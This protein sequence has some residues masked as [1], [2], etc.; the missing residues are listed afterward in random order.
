[1]TDQDQA[2]SDIGANDNPPRH[3]RYQRLVRLD[4]L[5]RHLLTNDWEQENASQI[6]RGFWQRIK[7]NA[8]LKVVREDLAAIRAPLL[9]I[10]AYCL[11][12]LIPDQTADSL[13]T[14][15]EES[16]VWLS[17][18]LLAWFM[19]FLLLGLALVAGA[20]IGFD[21]LDQRRTSYGR[22]AALYGYDDSTQFSRRFILT[23][24][25][26]VAIPLVTVYAVLA[27]H[28]PTLHSLLHVRLSVYVFCG[29][30]ILSVALSYLSLTT[31]GRP[32]NSMILVGSAFACASVLIL[33]HAFAIRDLPPVILVTV[34]IMVVLAGLELLELFSAYSRLPL[35]SIAIG[36]FV[37]FSFMDWNDNHELRRLPVNG[38][39]AGYWDVESAF[40]SWI[41][42]R[43]DES[44]KYIGARQ[45]YPVFIIAA[46]GG[47][48]R[49]AAMTAIVMETLRTVCP[50]A[51]KHTFLT[52]GVSGGSVGATLAHATMAREGLGS[53][54]GRFP[55]DSLGPTTPT[56]QAASDDLL[57]PLLFGTLF[58][59]LPSQVSPFGRLP[60]FPQL[61]DRAQYL[62]RGLS[63]TYQ[64]YT[65]GLSWWGL[66]LARFNPNGSELDQLPF[67]AL[68]QGPEG[69][70]PALMLLAT[71]VDSGRRV[72]ASHLRMPY[73]PDVNGVRGC[74]Q[75]ATD[76]GNLTVQERSRVISLS[77]LLPNWD[78]SASTAAILSARFPGITPAASVTCGERKYRLVDG[79]YFEN[80]GLTTAGEVARA[81]M[82]TAL[83][84]HASVHI[85]SIENSNASSD[86]RFARGL[87]PSGPPSYFS[88]LLSPFRAI[89]GSRE[90]HANIARTSIDDL[91]RSID[92]ARCANFVCIQQI[93]F[94][95]RR[96]PTP[97]PLGWSLSEAAVGEIR[98]QL[99]DS[100][101]GL[102]KDCVELGFRQRSASEAFLQVAANMKARLD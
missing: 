92:T 102:L 90:A 23:I 24:G 20:K 82:R 84:N 101:D 81:I 94:H 88:E 39:S 98:R 10:G 30:C 96:C 74:Q 28:A 46:E 86:W 100:S 53:G 31:R 55:Q 56:I 8:W 49:A 13:R 26:I 69:N 63:A 68:W 34:W 29:L 41:G 19:V 50:D 42:A 33:T 12:V 37:L 89:D 40:A 51:L 59:D 99:F 97:I 16:A 95:L 65:H 35:F 11:I 43:K 5:L 27:S 87:P 48:L 72:A 57:R 73:G 83:E 4:K 77:E 64:R 15:F 22:R 44:A 3:N 60:P 62:E 9:A 14:V 71:D 21:R 25:L 67:Q 70:I 2:A 58:A 75:L 47:G 18:I 38:A 6:R 32:F 80:S 91:I 79:G 93:R 78:V 85:I 76:S 17:A 66:L 7:R 36:L 52:I 54:C 1:L 61:T 45:P